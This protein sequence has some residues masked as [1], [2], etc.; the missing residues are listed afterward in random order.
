MKQRSSQTIVLEVQ[1]AKQ[2]LSPL[3]DRL[4][5]KV[6]VCKHEQKVQG[7]AVQ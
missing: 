1:E 5:N 7:N 4:Q 2:N 6:N 3:Q